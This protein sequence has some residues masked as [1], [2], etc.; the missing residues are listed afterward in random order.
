MLLLN[1]LIDGIENLR[2]VFV[3]VVSEIFGIFLVFNCKV[4]L[5]SCVVKV[6]IIGFDVFESVNFFY[7][8]IIDLSGLYINY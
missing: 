4:I 1:F 7:V 5:G 2:C 8:V 6:C 3:M